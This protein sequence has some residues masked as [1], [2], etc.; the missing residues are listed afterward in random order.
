[1]QFKI[2]DNI[3][4]K[5]SKEHET[6]KSYL[7]MIGVIEKVSYNLFTIINEDSRVFLC[8]EEELILVKPKIWKYGI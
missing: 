7:G 4:I 1:M 3:Q 6:P 8:Y 2:G 5:F